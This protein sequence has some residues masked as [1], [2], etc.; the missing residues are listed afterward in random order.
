[1]EA[2]AKI[3]IDL[4]SVL[5]YVINTGLLVGVLTYLLYKPVIGFLDKRRASIKESLDEAEEM[6]R[7]F[8]EKTAQMHMAEKEMRAA[9]EKELADGRRYV[10]EM[11]AKLTAEMQE[12]KQQMMEKAMADIASEKERLMANV[13]SDVL[14]TMQKALTSIL[15]TRVPEE[16]ITASVQEEWDRFTT[17]QTL[18]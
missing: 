11:K 4:W 3:G 17:S 1:M 8:E 15:L 5:L 2:L 18:S 9:F 6:R 13:R 12:Q 10:E 16:V 14:A 7:A